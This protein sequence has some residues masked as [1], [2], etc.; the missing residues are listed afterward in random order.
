MFAEQCSLSRALILAD[1]Y[2]K[3]VVRLSQNNCLM[4]S[5]V[6]ERERE[7]ESCGK[8]FPSNYLQKNWKLSGMLRIL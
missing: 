7:G 6:V 4:F 3:S 1:G 8:N 2:R 5:G